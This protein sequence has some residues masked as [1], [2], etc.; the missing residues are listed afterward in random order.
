MYQI[1]I[2]KLKKALFI[3]FRSL[4]DLSFYWPFFEGVISDLI[5]GKNLITI[6]AITHVRD[7]FNNTRSAIGLSSNYLKIPLEN[8]FQ[9][10]FTIMLWYRKFSTTNFQRI[11]ECGS[12]ED[13]SIL[14][15]A[16]YS[17][18]QTTFFKIYDTM[19][20][21]N[22][23][24]KS[25]I[26]KTPIVLNIWYHLTFV[27]QGSNGYIYVNGILDGQG[28]LNFPKNIFRSS[29]HLGGSLK[30]NILATAI[31]DDLKI[32]NR[33]LSINEIINEYEIN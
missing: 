14:M 27:L 20:D 25:V 10:D 6:R 33:A 11:I 15:S 26:G 2:V 31:F 30:A 18:V 17:D 22:D 32:F 3:L 28:D 16:S 7:R 8:F 24:A 9:G 29:C 4:S 13:D 12:R 21:L 1:S 5:N 23:T 19:N